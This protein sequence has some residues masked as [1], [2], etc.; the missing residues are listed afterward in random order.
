MSRGDL[1]AA[2]KLLGEAEDSS[3]VLALRARLAYL[4]R[5]ARAA[6]DLWVEAG[7]GPGSS[8]MTVDLASA[9]LYL[10]RREQARE[11]LERFVAESP[12]HARAVEARYSLGLL[13]IGG[14]SKRGLDL[15]RALAEQHP[16]NRWAWRAAGSVLAYG[17]DLDSVPRVAW[18]EEAELAVAAPFEPGPLPI[19]ELAKAEADAVEFLLATQEPSGYWLHGGSRSSRPEDPDDLRQAITAI[20][21]SALIEYR[22]RADVAQALERA[23]AWMLADYAH[24]LEVGQKPL[25]MD[26]SVWS[27][28]YAVAFLADCADAGVGERDELAL[29]AA[30]MIGDLERTQR[31]NGGWSYYMTSD[32]EGPSVPEH[33]ISFTTAAVVLGLARANDG[34]FPV[35]APVLRRAYEC[36]DGMLDDA[37]N[38]TYFLWENPTPQANPEQ[39]AAGRGPACSLAMNRCGSEQDLDAVR[40]ALEVFVRHRRGLMVEQGKALMH[41]GPYA[42]G[43][44]WVTFD[45]ATAAMA[46]ATLPEGE[47]VKYRDSVLGALLACRGT[48]GGFLDNPFLGWAVGTGLGLHAIQALK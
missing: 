17:L 18:P 44:H 6:R 19:E 31:S 41:C 14:G 32:L 4:R 9:E 40:H 47:R 16:E 22:E 45:Y 10:G 30:R 38:F 20:C 48:N 43:S 25:F 12:D 36:L 5:D 42:E 28:P 1:D 35:P 29:V 46:I 23:L 15:W 11:L 26:Y 7:A 33:S 21:G 3:S 34:G 13:S 37:N 2:G 39:G 8:P 27:R 24:A